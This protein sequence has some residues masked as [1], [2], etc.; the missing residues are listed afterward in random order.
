M[1][2]VTEIFHSP[3]VYRLSYQKKAWVFQSGVPFFSFIQIEIDQIFALNPTLVVQPKPKPTP[4]NKRISTTPSNKVGMEK[5]FLCYIILIMLF[6]GENT[7]LSFLEC[8]EWKSQCSFTQSPSTIRLLFV[9]KFNN[10]W[11]SNVSERVMIPS[12]SCY[13]VKTCSY[14]SKD[15]HFLHWA[16]VEIRDKVAKCQHTDASIW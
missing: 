16:E 6:M 13:S 8:K 3:S 10:N 4:S 7:F 2:H 9:L 5:V 15:F 1:D 14:P 11:Y 12:M